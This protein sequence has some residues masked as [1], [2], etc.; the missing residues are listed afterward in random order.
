MKKYGITI[1]SEIMWLSLYFCIV[2]LMYQ[3]APLTYIIFTTL[4]VYT[5]SITMYIL[6]EIAI[7]KIIKSAKEV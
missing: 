6:L 3:T 5:I 1:S 2:F 7:Q 4:F